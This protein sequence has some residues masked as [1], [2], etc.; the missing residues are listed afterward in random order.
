L[1]LP[2]GFFRHLAGVALSLALFCLT[3][4][5]VI[6]SIKRKD[7][8]IER[9]SKISLLSGIGS[10]R[11]HEL[12]I[13]PDRRIEADVI[14]EG[15]EMNQSTVQLERRNLIADG[16][17]RRRRRAADRAADLLE[18]RLYS[19]RER[20]DVLVDRL[21]GCHVNS[22]VASSGAAARDAA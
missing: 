1:D 20:R 12:S 4:S 15:C 16:L 5:L 10:N 7:R 9:K 18:N 19:G 21:C 11:F 8:L 22:Y 6:L 13:A 3:L 17:L 2:P 14:L